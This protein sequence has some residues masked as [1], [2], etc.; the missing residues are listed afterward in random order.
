MKKPKINAYGLKG[1]ELPY[2]TR[3]RVYWLVRDYPR[4]KQEYEDLLTD[5]PA[6][7]GQPGS[8]SPGDPTQRVAI[9]RA[10]LAEDVQAVEKALQYIP[11]EDA[12]EIMR[13]LAKR[14]E[15]TVPAHRNTWQNR[16]KPFLY[17]VAIIRGY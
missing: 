10:R 9:R 17:M 2:E 8:S 1:W 16:M 11:E 4:I 3:K 7:D 13:H 5:T 6:H 15:Y 12:R 14:K